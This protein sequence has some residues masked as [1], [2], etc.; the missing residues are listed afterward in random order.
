MGNKDADKVKTYMKVLFDE[1]KTDGT[2]VGT[3]V[4]NI[5]SEASLEYNG[6]LFDILDGK[7]SEQIWYKIKKGKYLET[8]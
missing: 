2:V 4:L 6:V 7:N 3:G 1:L 8:E 5:K